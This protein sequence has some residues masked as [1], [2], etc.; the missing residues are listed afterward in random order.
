MHTENVG[1][2]Y[3]E[4]FT[5]LYFLKFWLFLQCVP[6]IPGKKKQ[7]SLRKS[8]I[9]HYYAEQY[10]CLGHPTH[11]HLI[12]ACSHGNL[13]HISAPQG[14][15]PS[16]GFPTCLSLLMMSSQTFFYKS[17]THIKKDKLNPYGKIFTWM[18]FKAKGGLMVLLL[19]VMFSLRWN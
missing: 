4:I 10:F 17:S 6:F 12:G 14:C 11:P 5:F 9:L 2:F 18:H 7:F 15:R 16:P 8:K 3:T 19:R 13:C 1:N